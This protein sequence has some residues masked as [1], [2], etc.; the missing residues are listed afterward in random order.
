V[1]SLFLMSSHEVVPATARS[2]WRT[3]LVAS[4]ALLGLLVAG[5][6]VVAPAAQA[7]RYTPRA[8]VRF[9]D[10]LGGPAV[11]QR[12]LDDVLEAVDSAPRGSTIRF[13]SWN[14]R[15]GVVV[16]ALVAAHRRGVGV[17]VVMDRKNAY[18]LN[19]NKQ[20]NR[21]QQALRRSG[22]G[23]RSEQMKSGLR[24]C[25]ASCRGQ[26]GFAH[27]KFFL[28]S[29]S[30]KARQVV[31]NSSANATDLSAYAQ[32]N[33]AYTVVGDQ[34]IYGAFAAVF[35][36][37]F[38]DVP[39][40]QPYVRTAAGPTVA[41]FFPFRGEGTEVDPVLRELDQVSCTGATNT[42]SGRTRIRIAMTSW[43]GERGL[44]IG[45]KVRALAKEGCNIRVVYAVM[46][47]QLLRDLRRPGAGRVPLRHIVQDPDRDGIYDRYLHAKVLTIQGGYAE[48][49]DATVTI[50]GSANWTPLSLLSDEA[51]L[52]IESSGVLERY[53]TWI[54]RLYFHPPKNPPATRGGDKLMGG[55]AGRRS[56]TAPAVDPYAKVEVD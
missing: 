22:N 45:A 34:E 37:M 31:I 35:D 56:T 48:R 25:R 14:I 29:Q 33:E 8:G 51:V 28:F 4:I 47:T 16:D 52:R 20:V 1:V 21:L 44:A 3:V 2:P 23:K 40:A 5:L 55:A 36:E 32:W 50:N 54:D 7:E 6:L 18:S 43:F 42:G 24:K 9:N 15:G 41:E 46:G 30:G 11:Q 26:N 10:P 53:N 17:R 49:R 38:L 13:A 12:I 19:V 27:S 39:V